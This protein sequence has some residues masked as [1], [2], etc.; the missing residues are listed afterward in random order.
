MLE[1]LVFKM[2]VGGSVMRDLK[3]GNFICG[4]NGFWGTDC[5]SILL[6]VFCKTRWFFTLIVVLLW[7]VA[8][9]SPQECCAAPKVI[10]VASNIT[11]PPSAH[12][13]K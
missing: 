11:C 12:L 8:G 2:N 4:F 3:S 6:N 13:N 10:P 1:L 5:Q 7:G 9:L